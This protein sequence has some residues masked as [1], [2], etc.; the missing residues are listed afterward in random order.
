MKQLVCVL[1][2]AWNH[3]HPLSHVW[4]QRKIQFSGNCIPVDHN[5]PLWPVNEFTFSF[6]LQ[7]ISGSLSRTTTQR[8]ESSETQ[9]K[10]THSNTLR[11]THSNTEKYFPFPK[12]SIF[13]KYVFSGKYF[14]ATK[15]SLRY[16]I[17][18]LVFGG[19]FIVFFFLV[20]CLCAL[21]AKLSLNTK[22]NPNGKRFYEC[23]G[24][25]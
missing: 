21:W 17:Y 23:C 6:S 8:E 14:T 18:S 16:T 5:F 13:G 2:C 22:E 25:E 12:I 3:F 11:S 9:N 20:F 15:H 7:F 24:E 19:I 10:R 1:G 4:L